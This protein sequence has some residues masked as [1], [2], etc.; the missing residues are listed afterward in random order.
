MSELHYNIT[1]TIFYE[2]SSSL[3]QMNEEVRDNVVHK[4]RRKERPNKQ[5]NMDQK[6]EVIQQ[7]CRTRIR[8]ASLLG[9]NNKCTYIYPNS[10][11]KHNLLQKLR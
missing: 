11:D 3:K 9:L 8:T 4:R 10:T 7:N 5:K 1:R 6:T 2:S